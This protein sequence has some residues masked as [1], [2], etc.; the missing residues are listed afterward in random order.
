MSVEPALSVS[1]C[2]SLSSDP[3]S[4]SGYSWRAQPVCVCVCLCVCMCVHVFMCVCVCMCVCVHTH[5]CVCACMCVCVCTHACAC[6]YVRA[7]VH[8]CVCVHVCVCV[9]V[10][11][12]VWLFVP[13]WTVTRGCSVRGISQAGI[14]EWVSHFPLRGFSWPGDQTHIS[15]TSSIDW[16]ILYRWAT[17]EAPSQPM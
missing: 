1:C 17:W 16:Q 15:C 2:G 5:T 14:L 11:N 12:S 8:T 13:P 6:V 7:C 9:C 4:L 3:T 10:L